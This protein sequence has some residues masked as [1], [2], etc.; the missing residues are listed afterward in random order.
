M[1]DLLPKTRTVIS[2]K[3]EDKRNPL[4]KY[5]DATKPLFSG[6]PQGKNPKTSTK[7][8]RIY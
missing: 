8:K 2:N 3:P 6:L 7:R 5:S 4:Q 1:L